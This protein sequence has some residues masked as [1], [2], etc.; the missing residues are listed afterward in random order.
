MK[1]IVI[2]HREIGGNVHIQIPVSKAIVEPKYWQLA[3]REL[4]E[5]DRVLNN[6]IMTNP[7]GYLKASKDAFLTLVNSII[8]QQ[9]SLR[10]ADSIKEKLENCI[11]LKPEKIL[12]LD[13]VTMRKCGLSRMKISYLKDISSKVMQGELNFVQLKNMTDSEIIY[14]L[15]EI[16]GV[17]EWTAQMFLIF[18][19]TRPNILPTKDVGLINSIKY[20]YKTT[21][22]SKK[23]IEEYRNK[24]D[25]WC[26]VAAWYL[27]KNIDSEDT[28]Y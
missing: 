13:E 16:R 22:L 4:S 18:C 8:G 6:I 2:G 12:H 14:K 10:A 25:P 28:T 26:T 5:S 1:W 27:W 15:T 3:K 20:A 19:L 11:E 21:E 23:D 7:A 24:W 17:G 9:L